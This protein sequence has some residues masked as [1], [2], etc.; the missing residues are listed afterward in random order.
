MD[1]MRFLTRFLRLAEDVLTLSVTLA[2]DA[3]DSW[4]SG[5]SR[6]ALLTRLREAVQ[7][8]S[9]LALDK[10]R[11]EDQLDRLRF[12][13]PSL[14][15]DEVEAIRHLL[16][17]A[18]GQEHAGALRR[19]LDRCDHLQFTAEQL[20]DQID[21][22]LSGKAKSY[23]WEDMFGPN[24]PGRDVDEE[25]VSEDLWPEKSFYESNKQP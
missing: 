11:L 18:D 17:Y 14:Y 12:S 4:S 5:E 21:D 13:G 2:S 23:T 7:R 25:D 15:K 16:Q 24:D 1:D 19:L 6:Q 22:V 8:S 10:A 20:N 3:I 9:E